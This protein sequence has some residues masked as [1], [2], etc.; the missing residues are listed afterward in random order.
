VVKIGG[1]VASPGWHAAVVHKVVPMDDEG[2]AVLVL[3]E[4]DEQAV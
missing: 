1:K 2:Q 3:V 4:P